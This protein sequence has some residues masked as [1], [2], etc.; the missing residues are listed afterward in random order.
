[1]LAADRTETDM[2]D[3]NPS[4]GEHQR[5]DVVIVGAG[6]AGAVCADHLAQAGVDVLLLDRADFPRDKPCAGWITPEVFRLLSLT[7]EQLRVE[8]GA[9]GQPVEAGPPVV[10]PFRAF[11][12][13]MIGG[14]ADRAVLV[15]YAQPI[16]HGIRRAEFDHFL[17]GRARRAG[18]RMETGATV[19]QIERDAEGWLIDGHW[20]GRLLIGAGGHFCPVARW[21]QANADTSHPSE[22]ALPTARSSPTKPK[23]CPFVCQEVE[24]PLPADAASTCPVDPETPELYFCRDLLGY[25]WCIRKGNWLNIGLG[26]EDRSA[27][28]RRVEQFVHW[29]REQKRL[30]SGIEL[31]ERWP[32]HAYFAYDSAP[33][34]L[35]GERL[36]LVG[37][38]AGLAEGKTGEGIAP[39][40]RSGLFAARTIVAA[41]GEYG[42]ALA[43]AYERAIVEQF[44]ARGR[45]SSGKASRWRAAL[46]RLL[47]R[48]PT[49]VR[50]VVCDRWFLGR[51]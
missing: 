40:I 12:V 19:R 43:T 30:P 27:L 8:A 4:I 24:L 2:R 18:A 44:G 39:A 16:S 25:A 17:L 32:G 10:Q 48:N 34:P 6:P 51:G 50:R 3:M 11:R 41:K 47:L 31:P 38:A 42:P 46:G 1:V 35:A 29:L 37:D 5:V 28:P 13:G 20:H 9:R 36:L 21:M 7:P 45:R 22:S 26:R 23:S 14:R 49:F 33:R 15:D